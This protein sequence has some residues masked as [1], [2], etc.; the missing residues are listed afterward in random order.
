MSGQ[1]KFHNLGEKS[2]LKMVSKK[3]EIILIAQQPL[4][5]QFRIISKI[6]KNQGHAQNQLN[7]FQYVRESL[8]LFP[9]LL[10]LFYFSSQYYFHFKYFTS[11]FI[12]F[13]LFVSAFG[14]SSTQEKCCYLS[15][16]CWCFPC[17]QHCLAHDRH[18]RNTA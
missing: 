1:L 11:L 16:S 9:I 10:N 6:R 3:G 18:F 14:M 17:L 15:P 4:V 5:G 13:M 2:C 8:I 7:N 12:S